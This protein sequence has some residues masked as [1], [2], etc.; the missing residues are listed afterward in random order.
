MCIFFLQAEDG[1][2]GYDVTGV[3]TCALPI[4]SIEVPHRD[5]K[6]RG[7]PT[8]TSTQFEFAISLSSTPMGDIPLFPEDEVRI[9]VV[10]HDS[11]EMI[12]NENSALT[13]TLGQGS[14]PPVDV[15]SFEIGRAHV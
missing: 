12:P 14:V 7:A 4:Y 6:F 15:L 5:I 11:N 3:Q 13:Y 9:I 2:R 1:I 10:D 8:V